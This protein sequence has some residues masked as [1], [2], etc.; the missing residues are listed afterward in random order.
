MSDIEL[1]PVVINKGNHYPNVLHWLRGIKLT[2]RRSFVLVKFV[3]RS[4]YT[5]DPTDQADWNKL[6]GR[7]AWKFINGKLTRCEQWYVWRWVPKTKMFEVAKYTNIGGKHE[8]FD[9][10]KLKMYE[11]GLLDNSWFTYKLPLSFH[12][13]GNDSNKDGIG[14]VAPKKITFFTT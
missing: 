1:N 14:G 8:S 13:G 2:Y 4:K 5:L 3:V 12:F 9:V 7:I 6:Y 10:E 11:I